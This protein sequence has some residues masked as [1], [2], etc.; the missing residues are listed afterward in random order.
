MAS[1]AECS[2]GQGANTQVVGLHAIGCHTV[3]GFLDGVEISREE[4]EAMIMAARVAAGWVEATA[5]EPSAEAEEIAPRMVHERAPVTRFVPGSAASTAEP[6]QGSPWQS[7]QFSAYRVAPS[8]A[9]A[10]TVTVVVALA[11]S[12]E[13]SVTVSVTV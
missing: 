1:G 9:A 2:Q 13:S 11:V 12:P 4:A 7:A 5:E 6:L 10:V 8:F 3:A